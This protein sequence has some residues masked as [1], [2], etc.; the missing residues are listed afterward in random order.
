MIDTPAQQEND[1][2]S[3]RLLSEADSASINSTLEYIINHFINID[4][5]GKYIMLAYFMEMIEAS[6]Y[7]TEEW[8][9]L[10]LLLEHQKRHLTRPG[11]VLRVGFMDFVIDTIDRYPQWN[12][13]IA[14]WSRTTSTK[15][16][17]RL[18][19]MVAL[20][21]NEIAIVYDLLEHLTTIEP[22][23]DHINSTL[24]ITVVV[25]IICALHVDP[26]ASSVQDDTLDM[27]ITN[28][29]AFSD[30]GL[31]TVPSKYFFDQCLMDWTV[32]LRWIL[33]YTCSD[34]R[35]ILRFFMAMKI[36]LTNHPTG[37]VIL[38][39]PEYEHGYSYQRPPMALCLSQLDRSGKDHPEHGRLIYYPNAV[40][41]VMHSTWG[42][43]LS[44]ATYPHAYQ[45]LLQGSVSTSGVRLFECHATSGPDT[46]SSTS[47]T[48]WFMDMDSVL[49]L[50]N[51]RR[52]EF[53]LAYLLNKSVGGRGELIMIMPDILA[54]MYGDVARTAF[55]SP[56]VP[57]DV[58]VALFLLFRD[59]RYIDNACVFEQH[60][61][62]EA[63]PEMIDA[64]PT[65]T[66]REIVDSVHTYY[67]DT[68]GV[69]EEEFYDRDASKWV[70][71]MPKSAM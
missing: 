26:G 59:A 62:W 69:N 71:P 60:I 58:A 29:V 49:T 52:G 34:T 37:D 25:Q 35:G 28:F 19:I 30:D 45:L 36:D 43:V 21:M 68:L 39:L 27:V 13:N 57:V 63:T 38:G 14:N 41:S 5:T 12:W 2:A 3:R 32:D 23:R 1:E 8:P 18:P 65:G 42:R 31:C 40:T 61:F 46:P 67:R 50:D 22:T 51:V 17:L 64:L 70:T 7:P 15:P 11:A 54:H 56:R 20:H 48:R 53:W 24:V 4:T 44:S 9:V 66:R 55:C 47:D 16:L 10:N 6:S 33:M